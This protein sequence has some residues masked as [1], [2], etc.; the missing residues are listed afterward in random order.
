MRGEVP[1]GWVLG[2]RGCGSALLEASVRAAEK[3]GAAQKSGLGQLQGRLRSESDALSNRCVT[4]RTPPV[5]PMEESVGTRKYADRSSRICSANW[6]GCPSFPS[7]QKYAALPGV[8][9]CGG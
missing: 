1:A 9:R 7:I 8:S 3:G 6:S 4:R 2:P 5:H